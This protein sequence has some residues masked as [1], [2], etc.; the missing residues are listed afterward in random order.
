M[1]FKIAS[2]FLLVS[3]IIYP[4]GLALLALDCKIPKFKYIKD[5]KTIIVW[6]ID[7]FFN[8]TSIKLLV[9]NKEIGDIQEN[10]TYKIPEKYQHS[11]N[12]DLIL[13]GTHFKYID[14]KAVVH[15]Q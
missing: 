5:E 14:F 10:V 3:P 7:S 4:V 6:S 8:I 9:N 1:L 2:S 13:K 12:M 11:K 15:I